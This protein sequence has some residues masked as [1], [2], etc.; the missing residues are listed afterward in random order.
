MIFLREGGT[1]VFRVKTVNFMGE[2]MSKRLLLRLGTTCNNGCHHCTIRDLRGVHEDRSTLTVFESLEAG[3]KS[4]AF[5]VA[6]LRGEP[7]IR[8]DF[9]RVI[10]RAR[11]LGYGLVQIQTNGRMFATPGFTREATAAGMTHAEVSYYGPDPSIHDD[12]ARVEGAHKETTQGIRK[13]AMEGVLCHVNIPLLPGN[14]HHLATMLEQLEGWGVERIQLNLTRPTA[15]P[16][17]SYPELL[18]LSE[19]IEPV[20]EAIAHGV[21]LDVNV[22][23]EGIPLCLLGEWEHVAGDTFPPNS[24]VRIDDLHRVT[25]D[26]IPL[27]EEYRPFPPLCDDCSAKGRC[28]GT[29]RNLLPGDPSSLLRPMP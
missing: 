28:P 19:A 14:I 8:P 2:P 23:T 21:E 3:R 24:L 10:R 15:N 6:F 17:G 25:E 5:E 27:R 22:G 26:L 11:D 9:L 18:S 12:I 13:L 7:T 29:W 4:G 16:Q 1:K 20:K